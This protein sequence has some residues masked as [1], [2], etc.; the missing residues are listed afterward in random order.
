MTRHATRVM[1]KLMDK[2]ESHAK[3]KGADVLL[4]R[5]HARMASTIT[6]KLRPIRPIGPTSSPHRRC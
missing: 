6:C 1:G 2:D 3:A 4:A 5:E